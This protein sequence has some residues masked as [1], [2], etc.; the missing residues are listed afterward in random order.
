MSNY[1]KPLPLIT[2]TSKVFYD[3]CRS[4]KLLYQ[5]CLDCGQVIFFPQSICPGC[6]SH[7]IEWK[8]SKGKGRLFT[9]TITHAAAPSEFSEDTPYVLAIVEMDEG[10]KMM[11][12]I[13]E[14]DFDE[15]K[16]DMEV[17]VVF[18]KVTEEITLPKFRKPK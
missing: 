16:C 14:T 13:I 7:N 18:D 10:Y 12:N 9:F 2:P 3:G 4:G 1:K 17:E 5:Q 15:I 8:Q 11:T 6:L